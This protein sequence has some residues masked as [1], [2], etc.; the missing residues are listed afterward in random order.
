[1]VEKKIKGRKRHIVTDSQGHILHIEIHAANIHD[2]ISGCKVIAE[3][4]KKYQDLQII[5]GDMGYRG[6]CFKYVTD[7]LKK[8]MVISEKIKSKFVIQPM[9][10]VVER[11]FS[12]LNGYRRLAKDFE[13]SISSSESFVMIA[14]ILN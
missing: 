9:R 4:L 3:T 2:T 10:W 6:T 12:W 8:T 14:H 5:S 13:Y 7:I 1:M 11:T